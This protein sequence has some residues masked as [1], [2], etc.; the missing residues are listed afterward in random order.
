MASDPL[1]DLRNRL[2]PVPSGDWVKDH[3]ARLALEESQRLERRQQ[4]LLE[5]VSE[6]NTPA[7]RIRIWERRHGVTLPRDSNHR[8]LI[9]VAAATHLAL[10]QVREEQQRRLAGIKTEAVPAAPPG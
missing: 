4:E 6:R 2:P 8:V 10:H 3:R 9:I 1:T 5:Q 7:E